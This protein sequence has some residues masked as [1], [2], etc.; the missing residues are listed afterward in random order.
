MGDAIFA[1]WLLGYDF[2]TDENQFK[3]QNPKSKIE[4][5]EDDEKLKPPPMTAGPVKLRFN[6]P[7]EEAIDYFKRKKVLPAKEFYD[8]RNEARSAAFTVSGIYQE[9]VLEGFRQEIENALTNGTSQQKVIKNFKNILDGAGH[10]ELGNFHLET[11]F[12]TNMQMAYGVG[13]R[14]QME[15][16][17][18]LLPYWQYSAVNDDRT[19]PTHRAL[20][21]IVLP[22]NHEFWDTHYPPW[23]WNCRCGIIS[24]PEMPEDYNPEF[25]NPDSQIS[26]DK[27]GMPQKALYET[28]VH[29]LSAGKFT[30]V[31]RQTGLKETIEEASERAIRNRQ[32]VNKRLARELD[33]EHL[34]ELKTLSS[35][36]YHKAPREIIESAKQ[37]QRENSSVE[38]LHLY[39]RTGKFVAEIIGDEKGVTIPR[40]LV[41]LVNG[42]FTVHWHPPEKRQFFE[43]FSADDIVAAVS[44]NEAETFVASQNY[45]YSMRPTRGWT[46]ELLEKI[47]KLYD[48]YEKDIEHELKEKLFRNKMS[49]A[50]IRD[51]ARHEIWK[52]IARKLGLS[53]KRIKL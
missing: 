49:W 53:Y 8:I 22:A 12:R 19:R 39:D 14:K 37:F 9:D 17:S 48:R 31:P 29:D 36:P 38:K 4:F 27:K 33:K 32:S 18:D 34:E 24:L 10:R 28:S 6:V 2:A 26:Y 42:G 21:G 16:I 25:P 23:G 50:E 51:T 45:L 1:S 11:V 41:P 44:E 13:R 46:I 40:E 47:L 7:P 5:A 20:D 52:R 35:P 43:S 15:D 3:I 30:G